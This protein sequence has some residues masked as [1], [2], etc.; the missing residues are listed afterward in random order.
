MIGYWRNR[1]DALDYLPPLLDRTIP[2]RYNTSTR[3]LFIVEN[4][5]IE[6]WSKKA[7]YSSFFDKCDPLYCTYSANERPNAI[8]IITTLVGIFSGLNIVLKLCTPFLL[9]AVFWCWANTRG[10]FTL[11][12]LVRKIVLLRSSA[13]IS[14]IQTIS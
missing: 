8:F 4:L 6:Q 11:N 13:F 2:S 14:T 1:T 10:M 9:R 7:L 12:I 3:I 5:M